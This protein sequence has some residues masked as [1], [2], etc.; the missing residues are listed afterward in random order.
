MQVDRADLGL[1]WRRRLLLFSMLPVA[2]LAFS[3]F[4]LPSSRQITLDGGF[5]RLPF[6]DLSISVLFDAL[7]RLQVVWGMHRLADSR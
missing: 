5:T 3:L 6:A 4:C 7:V 2:H 1:M